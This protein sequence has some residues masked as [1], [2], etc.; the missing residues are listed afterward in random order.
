[1]IRS[2]FNALAATAFLVALAVA[3]PT[4]AQVAF[5]SVQSADTALADF[6]YL[7][8]LGEEDELLKKVD[9]FLQE[10]TGGKG[11]DGVDGKRP[12]GAYVDWP[13]AP[14]DLFSGKIPV[15]YFIPVTDD[16]R[17]VALLEKLHCK[18]Q[19][20]EGARH[21]VS[22][23]GG[24]E[25]FLQFAHG[26]A[27]AATRPAYLGDTPHDPATF[28]PP[29]VQKHALVARLRAAHFPR[30]YD[31]FLDA[32]LRPLVALAE[33]FSGAGGKL[34]GE[35]DDQYRRRRALYNQHVKGLPG[36]FKDG[37]ID[38]LRQTRE[39]T[40]D[41]D[42]DRSA[43][44]LSLEAAVLPRPGTGLAKAGAYADGARSRFAYL[45][46]NAALGLTVHFPT[47]PGVKGRPAD[48]AGPAGD[49]PR[50]HLQ[51]GLPRDPPESLPGP[52]SHPGG[53]RPGRVPGEERG[54]GWRGSRAA[55]GSQGPQRQQAG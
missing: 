55:G 41:L 48:G 31:K 47:P 25:L 29:G 20:A 28:L 37:L 3:R 8:A 11:L 49:G 9:A 7:A 17:F 35:T 5:V 1:M 26:H 39:V 30:D 21:R 27:F 43:H 36:R 50:Q 6:R 14:G 23:P 53:R 38:L 10:A 34:P 32:T 40:L 33:A 45:S 42:V 44:R 51:P 4:A 15:V 46:A 22:V 54:P 13:A 24:T 16:R 2:S 52:G 19:P 12:F 18:I